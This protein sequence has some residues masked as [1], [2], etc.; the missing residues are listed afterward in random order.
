MGHAVYAHCYVRAGL[1][2]P[3]AD[4]ASI[5]SLGGKSLFVP[6]AESICVSTQDITRVLPSVRSQTPIALCWAKVN[7]ALNPRLAFVVFLIRMSI[8][9]GTLGPDILVIVGE[10]GNEFGPI[11][12]LSALRLGFLCVLSIVEAPFWLVFWLSRYMDSLRF[13]LSRRGRPPPDPPPSSE[14]QARLDRE[15]YEL[16]GDERPEQP[17][18]RERCE[19]GA[20]SH[21]ALCR[22]HHFENIRGRQCPFPD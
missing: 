10:D 5:E 3:R 8:L 9:A 21:S 22:K 13:D 7:S 16:L 2:P 12:E 14:T 11:S 17:C 1:A 18:Q 15:F 4:L 6:D 20:I 19:R